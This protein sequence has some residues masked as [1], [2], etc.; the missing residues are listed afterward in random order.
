MCEATAVLQVGDAAGFHEALLESH[1]KKLKVIRVEL[2]QTLPHPSIA[3]VETNQ[4]LMR[5]Q[6]CCS[7]SCDLS[8]QQKEINKTHR[9]FL[10]ALR[11][12][13]F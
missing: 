9:C 6:D 8:S 3:F 12:F 13:P 10:V 11:C 2:G 7:L 5:D 1:G 4:T